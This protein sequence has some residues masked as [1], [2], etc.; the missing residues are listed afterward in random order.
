MKRILAVGLLILTAVACERPTAPDSI[1]IT[2]NNS[3][4]NNNGGAGPGVTPSP[5]ICSAITSVNVLAPDTLAVSTTVFADLDATP[6]PVRSDDCNI[7]SPIQWSASP[8]A[9]CELK[10]DTG[11]YNTPNLQCKV[12]GTCTLAVAVKDVASGLFVT[13]SASVTCQ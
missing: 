2:N 13:G 12:A 7:A 1:V 5:G 10:G 9:T 6:R 8:S 11:G 3:N 4:Q